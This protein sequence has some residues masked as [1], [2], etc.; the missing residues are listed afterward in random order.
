MGLMGRSR[1]WPDCTLLFF[2]NFSYL[3]SQ[4]GTV[5]ELSYVE[6]AYDE[7]QLQ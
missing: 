3:T 6:E 1:F 7:G 2:I 5:L 4:D